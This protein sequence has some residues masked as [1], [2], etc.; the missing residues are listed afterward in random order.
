MEALGTRSKSELKRLL[1]VELGGA[2]ERGITDSLR[3]D[4]LEACYARIAPE[5]DPR[6]RARSHDDYSGDWRPKRV[7]ATAL[8]ML[9]ADRG[10]RPPNTPLT[11]LG[12]ES[13]AQ[14]IVAIRL[15]DEGV[16]TADAERT[17]AEP[18]EREAPPSPTFPDRLSFAGGIAEPELREWLETH[19]AG[20][21]DAFAVYVLDCTPP[22]D[23]EPARVQ[24]LR[25]RVAD[26]REAGGALSKLE[27]AAAA[28]TR[29]ERVYYVGYTGDIV[30]RI[31]RH[32]GGG[33]HGTA[34]FLH[35]FRPQT[36]VEVTPYDRE[37]RARQRE[38]E[39]ARELTVPGESFAYWE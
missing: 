8:R 24:T 3:N 4:F 9:L 6:T 31:A 29:G 38:A 36:L 14:I 5:E 21:P 22:I 37:H 19:C 15:R 28:V 35:T 12:A 25:S 17:V 32:V 11:S 7:L 27:Q 1:E 16:D 10:V 34:E 30:D 39:R 18:P 33:A 2:Y 26:K 23:G 20:R 13:L